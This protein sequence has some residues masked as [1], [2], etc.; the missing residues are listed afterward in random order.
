MEEVCDG[1]GQGPPEACELMVWIANEYP[2]LVDKYRHLPW[3]W[4]ATK[5]SETKYIAIFDSSIGD[6]KWY[7]ASHAQANFGHR[8]AFGSDSICTTA[9][10]A[11]GRFVTREDGEKAE[12]FEA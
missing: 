2:E 11:T 12:I 8:V 10:Q 9:Y 4:Y 6:Y 1:E 5:A 7:S 3:G